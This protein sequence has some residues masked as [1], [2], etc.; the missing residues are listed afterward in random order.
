[1]VLKKLYE[2]SNGE[3][4]I[5]FINAGLEGAFKAESAL[6]KLTVH[7]V[8]TGKDPHAFLFDPESVIDD[9]IENV[10]REDFDDAEH[11]SII[12]PKSAESDGC[13]IGC[14]GAK[15]RNPDVKIESSDFVDKANPLSEADEVSAFI[16]D[17]DSSAKCPSLSSPSFESALVNAFPLPLCRFSRASIGKCFCC[18]FSF[19]MDTTFNF[20]HPRYTLKIM[21]IG[22]IDIGGMKNI[23]LLIT[24]TRRPK[25]WPPNLR[26]FSS[27]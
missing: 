15:E 4:R 16:L 26:K 9:V 21:N 11:L 27:T 6:V 25:L 20:P 23:L 10:S 13:A 8:N 17:D 12:G 19:G 14:K 22:G 1:M 7:L 5:Q 24:W 3:L 2:L 18:D